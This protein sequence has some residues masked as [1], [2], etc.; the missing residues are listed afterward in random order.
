VFKRGAEYKEKNE[1]RGREVGRV[2]REGSVREGS[3][4]EEREAREK[5]GLQTGKEIRGDI[6]R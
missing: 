6:Y 2:A 3:I 1:E 5:A 4:R